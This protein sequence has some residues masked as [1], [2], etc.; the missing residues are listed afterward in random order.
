MVLLKRQQDQGAMNEF[1][2]RWRFTFNIR[3][4]DWHKVQALKNMLVRKD[5]QIARSRLYKWKAIVVELESQIQ[6]AVMI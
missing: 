5:D 6:R 4:K 2:T 1:F 3:F